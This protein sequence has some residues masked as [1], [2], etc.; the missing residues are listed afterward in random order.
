MSNVR[1]TKD[2][3]TNGEKFSGSSS[4][5][6]ASSPPKL[7]AKCEALADHM[8]D[9]AR[10]TSVLQAFHHRVAVVCENLI[11]NDGMVQSQETRGCAERSF[12][13]GAPHRREPRRTGSADPLWLSPRGHA[14]RHP[15]PDRPGRAA[16]CGWASTPPRPR[17][18][19][20]S[21]TISKFLGI[22]FPRAVN[23]L[24]PFSRRI[25]M[26]ALT[27]FAKYSTVRV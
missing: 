18:A 21:G 27:K 17:A 24:D 11:P 10:L 6:V 14:R 3:R 25:V 26:F 2:Q 19:C 22:F 15:R 4:Q 5:L 20:A 16:P 23:D 7:G 8:P 1:R 12:L 13:D 9:F